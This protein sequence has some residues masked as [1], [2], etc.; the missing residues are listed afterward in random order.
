MTQTHRADDAAQQVRIDGQQLALLWQLSTRA[1]LAA[2]ETTLGFTI[3]NETLALVPY[4]QAAWWRG[5]TPGHVAAVSGLPQS[6]PNAPYVQW[7]GALCK[8]LAHG[9]R[10]APPRDAAAHVEGHGAPVLP[11]RPKVQT[12]TAADLE[13]EAPH[14]A[15]EWEAWWPANGAWLP[16]T[17]RAGH[18]VGG[19]VFA[20]DT[21][22]SATDTALLTELG[23]V[24]AHA[25]EAFS[26]RASWLERARAVLRP[27]RQQRRVLIGVA[28]VCVIPMRLTVLAPAEVTPKDP[29]VVRSPLDG[30]IDRLYVKPNQ[31]VQAGTPLL[32]LDAT[33][34][35]SRYAVARKDYDTA[36]EEFRQ[37]EQLAVTD[38][39]TRL[40]MAERRGKLDQSRV[41]LDYTARQLAR[42]SVNAARSGVAVFS[43]PNE[44]TGKAVAVGEKIL[45]LAD[46]AHVEV[47]AWLPVADNIDVQPGTAL[48]L[49]PKSSPL[50]SYE[51]R[52]DSIAWRAEPTPEG[53]LA[54]RVRASF[55]TRDED[56]RQ[57]PLGAMGTAR[58]RGPWV[59]AI[60]Y[61][62][63][64]PLTLAR[65]WL[66]W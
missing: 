9:L 43:D 57:A 38:D 62:L 40:D 63:R 12:F 45:V 5:D 53:V 42:V 32:G 61:V 17:D 20:R 13:A 19:V 33:T 3:V 21:A 44:W 10:G 34:L 64:R 26:P 4:R 36:Q 49:Y 15:A 47:T 54:Y 39:R 7:L 8:A 22:W 60:Y 37:T 25:F 56:A 16:L 50:T 24:W 35:Q 18:P 29:F 27:G 51:A 55:D 59:P 28:V 46:P 6:D 14:V 23:Q 31:V 41:E 2:S 11:A 58:I 48:T 1:R 30:V 65:Q 52:V 66:G